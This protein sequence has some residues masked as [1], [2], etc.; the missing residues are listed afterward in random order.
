MKQIVIG[1][2][3]ML[4]GLFITFMIILAATIYMP[5]IN[6]WNGSKLSY[7][8][9]ESLSLGFPFV[10]G[11]LLSILGFLILIFTYFNTSFLK[12]FYIIKN[13]LFSK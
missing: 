2:F 11:I 9:F 1:G 8:I 4:A 10:I 12:L 3:I 6:S 13:H 5:T 7:A